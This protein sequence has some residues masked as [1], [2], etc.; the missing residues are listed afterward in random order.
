MGEW[1]CGCVVGILDI[2]SWGGVKW[3]KGVK[4]NEGF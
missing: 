3:G 1:V 4:L 2:G